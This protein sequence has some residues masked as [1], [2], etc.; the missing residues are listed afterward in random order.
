ML[1]KGVI[2][3]ENLR[4]L[5]DWSIKEPP[6]LLLP[7]MDSYG[8]LFLSQICQLVKSPKTSLKLP[9]NGPKRPKMVSISPLKNGGFINE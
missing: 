3:L 4:F 5:M 2:D 9:K 7:L 6:P 8:A 1:G